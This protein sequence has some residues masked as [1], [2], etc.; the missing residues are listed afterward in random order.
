MKHLKN[1]CAVFA[2][3]ALTGCKLASSPIV[4]ERPLPDIDLCSMGIEKKEVFVDCEPWFY[5]GRAGYEVPLQDAAKK[6]YFLIAPNHY[7][8]LEKWIENVDRDIRRV[9]K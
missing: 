3:V 1:L 6:K 2:V 5:E 7:R 9:I 4:R 8:A